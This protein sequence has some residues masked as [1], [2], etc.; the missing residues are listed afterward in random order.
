M[1]PFRHSR[2]TASSPP[3]PPSRVGAVCPLSQASMRGGTDMAMPAKP[4]DG[5][6]FGTQRFEPDELVVAIPHLRAVT[7]ALQKVL[8]V[9]DRALEV[10]PDD[11]LGLARV[12]LSTGSVVQALGADDDPVGRLLGRLTRD[13]AETQG[14]W[15]P[16]IG[17]NRTLDEVVGGEHTIGV[18]DE[19]IPQ[20]VKDGSPLALREGDPGAGVLV[21]IA[22]TVLHPSPWLEGAFRAPPAASWQPNGQP[23]RYQSGHATFVAGRV[24]R[25]APGAAL[26]VRRVLGVDGRA[27]SWSVAQAL[28]R[29]ERLGVDVLNLSF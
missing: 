21:G 28:V 25:K 18:G 29:F 19:G 10:E 6:E 3:L 22:D 9:G 16:G 14:G 15:T 27:D 2:V 8:G 23:P 4:V 17:R 20:A 26:S 11:G 12:Q 5:G 24:L 1:C 7:A 13:F